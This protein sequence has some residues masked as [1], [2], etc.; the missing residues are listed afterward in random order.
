MLQP[1]LIAMAPNSDEELPVLEAVTA[2]CLTPDLCPSGQL[3][4]RLMTV[5]Q[6]GWKVDNSSGPRPTGY[7]VYWSDIFPVRFNSNLLII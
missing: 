6:G 4:K 2:L 5:L 7:H 1:L 3:Y